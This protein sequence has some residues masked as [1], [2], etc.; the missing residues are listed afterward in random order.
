MWE[1]EPKSL[2]HKPIRLG[3]V[4]LFGVIVTL[5]A[6]AAVELGLIGG[7][8]EIK[9]D[10]A[11]PTVSSAAPVPAVPVVAQSSA[12]P[13][14]SDALAA[15]IAG[16]TALA[17][18]GD[19]FACIE[20][21]D[22]YRLGAGCIRDHEESRR[23]YEKAATHADSESEMKLAGVFDG[24]GYHSRAA[25]LY[26]RAA[27]R[28]VTEAQVKMGFHN[29]RS[30]SIDVAEAYAWFNVGAASGDTPAASMRDKL[31]E[32]Y[33]PE[34]ITRGQKRSREILKEIEAKKAKK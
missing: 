29:L 21:G 12:V 9:T 25:G 24:L 3:L 31:E 2:I 5:L 15:N 8:P 30:G 34:T 6:L 19:A 14:P 7:P 23:W 33:S 16:L 20:L 28:G 17:S 32:G 13:Q 27:L 4:V 18:G 26:E 22:R 10:A 11:M 1:I